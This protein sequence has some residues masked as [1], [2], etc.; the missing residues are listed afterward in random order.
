MNDCVGGFTLIDLP[1]PD[2]PLWANNRSHW[3]VKANAVKAARTYAWAAALAA[4][5]RKGAASRPVLAF[6]FYPPTARLPDMQNMPHT[7]KAAID[8]IAD[9]LGI[10][11]RFF[12]CRWPDNFGS[13]VRCGL[14]VLR[15][16]CGNE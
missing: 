15:V 14:V 11:D 6:D 13:P 12:V 3:A 8:G 10:D 2:R 9:A 1:W 7:Q 5:L 4:G 16:W